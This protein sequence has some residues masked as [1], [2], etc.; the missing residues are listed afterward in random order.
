MSDSEDSMVT[1][2]EPLP[3]N[4]SPT[5]DSPGYIPKSD[6]EEDDEDL[7]E[8]P[9]DYPT[10]RD[11]N[12]EDEEEESSGDEANDEDEDMEEEEEH[13][14]LVDSVPPPVYRVT[15]RMSVRAQTPVSL[16][17]EIEILSPLP[18]ILSPPL[19]IS[20]PP[21]HA[22]P[23]YPLGHRAVMIR[24]RTEAPS[25]SHQPPP[26]VLPHTKASVAMLRAAT[27]STYILA[28]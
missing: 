27:P 23:T 21:L 20:P 17:L 26:I 14:T 7:E 18:Q 28:P 16:L 8:D 22:S 19:P 1:Y 6:P 10:D 25:I 12:D 9:T 24:L 2:T 4:V 3:A 15:V 11:D 5:A 13:P